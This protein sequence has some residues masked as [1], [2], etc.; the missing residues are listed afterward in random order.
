MNVSATVSGH[1]SN[2][3]NALQGAFAPAI[4]NAAGSGDT[5]KML[6][7]TMQTCKFGTA[8]TAIFVIP[9][10]LEIHYVIHLWLKIVPPEIEGLCIVTLASLV[11]SRTTGGICG[12]LFAIGRIR[13]HEILNG[14]LLVL[15]LLYAWALC[16]VKDCGILGF[17]WAMLLGNASTEL[18]RL[19]LWRIILK[20]PLM[21]WFKE[22]FIPLT[23]VS[24]ISFGVG[25][26]PSLWVG[27]S[28]GRL[29]LS[30]VLSVSLFSIGCLGLLLNVEERAVVFSKLQRF[31]KGSKNG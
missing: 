5:K 10:C 28:F 1:A 31:G 25:F 29:V 26:L 20:Q 21:P 15:T 7:L 30:S 22:F 16:V 3:A 18:M 23:I 14:V 8:L 11:L 13:E 24:T 27:E 17:G 19:A 4:T 2:M 12:A 6:R 9:L